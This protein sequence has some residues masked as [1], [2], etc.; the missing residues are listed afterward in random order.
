MISL[1]VEL[2]LVVGVSVLAHALIA[3][4]LAPRRARESILRALTDDKVFQTQLVG[5]ILNNFLTPVDSVLPDGTHMQV[6]PIDPI[7]A[8]AKDSFREYIESQ[9]KEI[10]KSAGEFAE[11]VIANQE[12]PMLAMV[13]SQIPKKYRWLLPFVAQFMNKP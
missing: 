1:L 11:N 7:I 2:V 8:R 13:L 5:S 4:E 9:Q 12:N 10:E 6:V 3:Y